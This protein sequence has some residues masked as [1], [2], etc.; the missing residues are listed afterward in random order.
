MQKPLFVYLNYAAALFAAC[1]CFA[2]M[3]SVA[4]GVTLITHGFNSDVN[5]WV[6]AMAGKVA[7]YPGFPGTNYTTYTITLTTDG[8]SYFYSWSRTNSSPT[9]TDSGE[10]IVK[11][12]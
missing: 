12:D 7:N 3:P 4:G 1:V 2:P 8:T 10:V 11:L 5:S 9:A 6:S